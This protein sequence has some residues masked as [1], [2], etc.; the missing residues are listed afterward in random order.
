MKIQISGEDRKKLIQL[1]KEEFKCTTLK[2][3]SIKTKISLRTIQQWL[4]EPNYYIKK[5]II[6]KNILPKIIIIDEKEDN[7][8]KVKGGRKTYQILLR[9]YGYSEIKKRQSNGGKKS[10]NIIRKLRYNHSLNIDL[11]NPQFLE[12]YGILMGDGWL[13]KLKYKNKITYLIGISGHI[14]FDKD[15]HNYCKNNINK[16]FN[17]N[18][19]MKEISRSNA[20]ELLF[21]HK[22][23]FNFL[24]NNLGFPIGKKKNLFIPESILS[25]GYQNTKHIIRGIFDT[26]GSFYLDKT[27]SGNPYPC[28]C[29]TMK[30]PS[31]MNEINNI[32]L[33]EGFKVNSR[34]SRF[35]IMELKLKGSKQLKKWITE[36]GSSNPYKL[37]KMKKALVAQLDSVTP[38]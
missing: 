23:L 21:S 14:N 9:K 28:I 6:P 26:D 19:Y 17:R 29:I 1:L 38:S 31:L 36:I 37:N 20:R 24:I 11:K 30:Q 13:S 34:K 5:E 18:P 2:E 15:F 8:G 33:Q 7:W 35:P 22:E 12:F 25:G 16:L 10:I 32:L 27:P 3:L 4:Y